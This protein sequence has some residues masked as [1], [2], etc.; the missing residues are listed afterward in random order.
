MGPVGPAPD[1]GSAVQLLRF[2]G[3]QG[4]CTNG[5]VRF[6][7]PGTSQVEYACD[8]P[9]FRAWLKGDLQGGANSYY[10]DRVIFDEE[11][12]RMWQ[13]DPETGATVLQSL[14]YDAA[15]TWCDGLTYAGLSD[16]R[17]PTQ[18]ELISLLVLG[19]TP[20]APTINRDFFRNTP[21][22]YFWTIET[23]SGGGVLVDFTTGTPYTIG[24]N[25]SPHS[26]RCVR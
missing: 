9:R 3:S 1:A 5:G 17:L 7:V 10:G 22:D 11:T 18:P 24:S 23:N 16:W 6:T 20:V 13:R 19:Q 8:A 21:S 25:F 2:A 26:V 15:V 4:P 14:Q 12:G